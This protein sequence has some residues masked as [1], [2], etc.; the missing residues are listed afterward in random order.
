MI[1]GCSTS[2]SPRRR[3]QTARRKTEAAEECCDRDMQWWW[4]R[5]T[6]VLCEFSGTANKSTKTHGSR[7]VSRQFPDTQVLCNGDRRLATGPISWAIVDVQVR[8]DRRRKDSCVPGAFVPDDPGRGSWHL[9]RRAGQRS[10]YLYPCTHVPLP[11]SG[12]VERASRQALP[13]AHLPALLHKQSI[14]HHVMRGVGK[15]RNVRLTACANQPFSEFSR[16]PRMSTWTSRCRC[17]VMR[18]TWPARPGWPQV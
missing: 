18:T 4:G 10:T 8:S 16:G 9:Q 1:S 14:S 6:L 15:P 17:S 11:T 12:I 2:L 7:L 13:V 3:L 5:M